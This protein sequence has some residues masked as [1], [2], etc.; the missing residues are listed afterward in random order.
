LA[1]PTVLHGCETWG[2]REEDKAR[3]MSAEMKFLRRTAKYAWQD[4]ITNEDNLSKLN[5]NPVERKFKITEINGHN[6]FG[7]WTERDCHA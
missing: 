6:I 2:I 5:T 3:I 1:I 7:E 4:Y